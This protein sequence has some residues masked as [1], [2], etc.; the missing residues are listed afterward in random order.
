MIIDSNR[1][2]PS[3]ATTTLRGI[4]HLAEVKNSSPT[5]LAREI[6]VC[7]ASIT[8]MICRLEDHGY[9]KRSNHPND[10]RGFVITIT[11]E[12]RLFVEGLRPARV[13]DTREASLA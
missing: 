2:P 1:I 3:M 12:G 13:T 9:V 10:L 7:T 11:A 5:K 4:C 6:G 8:G